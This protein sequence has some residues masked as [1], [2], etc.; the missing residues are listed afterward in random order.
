MTHR[1]ARAWSALTIAASLVLPLAGCGGGDDDEPTEPS[2]S[3]L[4]P[5]FS[6]DGKNIAFTRVEHDGRV[7]YLMNADGTDPQ[8]VTPLGGRLRTGY[9]SPSFSPDGKRLVVAGD[10]GGI[11]L[12]GTDGTG[13]KALVDDDDY[14]DRE[15]AFS[16]DGKKIAWLRTT[17]APTPPADENEAGTSASTAVWIM[18]ADGSHQKRLAAAAGPDQVGPPAFSPDGR[19][20]AY[21]VETPDAQ[22][23]LW[24]VNA[25]GS[26]AKALTSHPDDEDWDPSFSS[27]G[28]RIVFAGV[29]GAEILEVYAMDADGTDPVQLTS[30]GTYS[31][32]PS[33]S[34]DGKKILFTSQRSGSREVWVMNADGTDQRQLTTF[35]PKS[36]RNS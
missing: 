13:L 25:D 26:D 23:H 31:E 3:A 7:V 17:L 20:I 5:A 14:E 21:V 15:P 22:R 33:Y 10:V 16:P 2:A 19:K 28:R 12:I 29:R 18:D 34:P 36:D 11:F 1:Q 27:D 35:T 9:E 4:R 30:G 32:D 8:A 24:V 6:P